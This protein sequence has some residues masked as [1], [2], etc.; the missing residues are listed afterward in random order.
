MCGVASL[1]SRIPSPV[2]VNYDPSS[3]VRICLAFARYHRNKILADI[4]QE[5]FARML[6]VV[7]HKCT[8]VNN[9][10]RKLDTCNVKISYLVCKIWRNRDVYPFR[11]IQFLDSHPAI[12]ITTYGCYSS[13]YE[14]EHKLISRPFFF[15]SISLCVAVFMCIVACL[16]NFISWRKNFCLYIN[17]FLDLLFARSV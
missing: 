16:T 5:G 17:I 13:Y 6:G 10:K 12:A 15:S 7:P 4:R 11:N 14:R 2:R 9:I 8:H 3:C 1:L